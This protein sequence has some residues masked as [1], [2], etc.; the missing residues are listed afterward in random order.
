M[1]PCCDEPVTRVQVTPTLDHL[2][3]LRQELVDMVNDGKSIAQPSLDVVNSMLASL[4]DTPLP[5]DGCND[6]S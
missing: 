4:A 2:L 5:C 6:S 3:A 1:K